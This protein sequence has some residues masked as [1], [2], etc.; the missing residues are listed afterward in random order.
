MARIVAQY[1]ASSIELS[2]KILEYT[3]GVQCSILHT[4]YIIIIIMCNVYNI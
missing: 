2:Q 4:L 3:Q 1:S